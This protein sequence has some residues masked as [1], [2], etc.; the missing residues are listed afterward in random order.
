MP[1]VKLNPAFLGI[2]GAMGNVVFRTSKN[3][4]TF[5]S[6]RPR[7]TTTPP[8]K[9]QLAQQRRFGEASKY[10][11]AALADP[12]LRAVYEEIAVDEGISPFAAARNDYL[13]GNDRLAKK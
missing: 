7:K 12:E 3:G 13:S 2:S 5:V 1:K 11:K 4:E 8:T 10:A 6:K 9:A